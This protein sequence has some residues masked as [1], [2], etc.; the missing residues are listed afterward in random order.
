M[1]LSSEMVLLKT[2][3]SVGECG[4]SKAHSERKE[5]GG[6]EKGGC[7]PQKI[8][9]EHWWFCL[10]G[11]AWCAVYAHGVCTLVR[12]HTSHL[13][14]YRS[15]TRTRSGGQGQGQVSSSISSH[16]WLHTG[17]GDL[18]AGPHPCTVVLHS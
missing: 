14:V 18:K 11:L 13:H 7:F 3:S 17:A 16:A 5:E 2:F 1:G 12:M 15:R 8:W 6:R 9:C 10:D 4:P